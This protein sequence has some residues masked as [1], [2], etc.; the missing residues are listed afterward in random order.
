LHLSILQ[1]SDE[2]I[3]KAQ[4]ATC[5]ERHETAPPT[6]SENRSPDYACDVSGNEDLHINREADLPESDN[7]DLIFLARLQ[8]EKPPPKPRQR[9]DVSSR[10]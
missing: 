9:K 1:E 2:T 6:V 10:L 8:Q 3:L 5:Q 4:L 7:D